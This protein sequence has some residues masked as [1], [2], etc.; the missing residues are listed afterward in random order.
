MPHPSPA[1]T[2][3]NGAYAGSLIQRFTRKLVDLQGP[4]L[5]DKD[6]EPLHQMRVTMRRLRTTLRQFGPALV[7]PAAVS[8]QRIGKSVRRLGMARDLDVLRQRLEESLVPQ[9]PPGDVKALKPVFKQLRRERQLAYEHLVAVLHSHGHLKLLAGLQSW[10]KAPR[11]TAIGDQPLKAWRLEWQLPLLQGLFLH[12]GWRAVDPLADAEV[13]HDLRKQIKTCRYTL[14]N[15][16]LCNRESAS[17]WILRFRHLQGVLGDLNDLQVLG[18]AIDDQLDRD[19]RS[20]L[21]GLHALL[22]QQRSACWLEWQRQ[23]R[24]LVKPAMRE[25]LL[26]NLLD[27]RRPHPKSCP[28]ELIRSLGHRPKRS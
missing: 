10:L 1:P 24:T 19:L 13:L 6:P 22:D 25:Q 15:L 18:K 26:H 16:R 5:A 21:P 17:G 20:D 2:L 12:P 7:L 14:E 27:P 3:S 11:Y 28:D 9:L 4:V 23:A 8:D